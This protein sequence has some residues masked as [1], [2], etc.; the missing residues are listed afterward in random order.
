MCPLSKAL[1]TRLN[2]WAFITRF[3]LMPVYVIY[4]VHGDFP[5]M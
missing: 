4:G 2:W 1:V 5:G 3:M